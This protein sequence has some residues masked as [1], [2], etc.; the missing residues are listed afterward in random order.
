VHLRQYRPP[1]RVTL[2]A[3]F[4]LTVVVDLTA[5]V[6]VGLVAACLTFIYRISSLTRAEA[7]ALQQPATEVQ[8]WRLYGA[9]FFG[10][11]RLVEAMEDRLPA[12]ALVLDLKNLI[13][14]DSSGADTLQDL[15]RTCQQ[16]GVRLVLCGVAHQPLDICRRTG[17][18][19]RQAPQDVCDDLAA[20]LAAVSAPA[21]PI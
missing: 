3:V 8:A 17:L 2:L 4:A 16:Q 7:V 11:V 13:Y 6:E 15:Q 18:L 1:Y 20:A 5:A 19:A 9:L 14:M 12:R 10:A 21:A